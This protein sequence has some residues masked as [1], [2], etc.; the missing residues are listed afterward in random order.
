MMLVAGALSVVI[1]FTYPQW[2]AYVPNL[3]R[4]VAFPGASDDQ[5]RVLGDM[6]GRL[7]ATAYTAMLTPVPIPTLRQAPVPGNGA[8][9]ILDG[10]FRSVDALRS[11]AGTVT[12][13]RLPTDDLVLHL[14]EFTVT[15][16]PGL[17]IILS[18]SDNPINTEEMRLNNVDFKV[19]DLMGTIGAQQYELPFGLELQLYRSVVIYSSAL[20]MI[21]S[22]APIS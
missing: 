4:A 22:V 20:D 13:Y 9:P 10:N 1:L 15:N 3:S 19:G 14:N 21:Y 2:R 17:E 6:D 8:Q 5:R 12:I 18:A 11:G 7:A 16:A